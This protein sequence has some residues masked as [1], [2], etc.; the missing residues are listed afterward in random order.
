M[1]PELSPQ[2]RI[3]IDRMKI[4]DYVTAHPGR[5]ITAHRLVNELQVGR[6]TANYWLYDRQRSNNP[7]DP[8]RGRIHKAGWG[9]YVYF[10]SAVPFDWKDR[11]KDYQAKVARREARKASAVQESP[12][13]PPLHAVSS[14]PS[15]GLCFEML[16]HNPDTNRV[17]LHD[18]NGDLW[19]GSLV[20]VEV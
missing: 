15:T 19:T 5:S 14:A 7:K 17:V 4:A 3:D 16:R 11:I 6:R 2:S 8:F 10:P 13:P 9:E 1:N 20:R 12:T 18:E